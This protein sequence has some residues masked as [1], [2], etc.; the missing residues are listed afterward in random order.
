LDNELIAQGQGTSKQEAQ[1][2]AAAEGLRNKS[3]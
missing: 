3:W 2:A 1:V